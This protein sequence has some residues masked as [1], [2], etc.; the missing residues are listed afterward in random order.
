VEF[1]TSITSG[2]ALGIIASFPLA[3]RQIV[4]VPLDE[5]P[6]RVLA[7][8]ITAAEEIP[9]FS[10][11]L[12]DGYA[13]KVKDTYGARESM[14][15]Q[16]V[17]TGEVRVGESTEKM[18]GDGEAVYV[19][20]GAML[21]EGADGVVMQEH[22][23]RAANDLEVTRSLR[24]GENICFAGEDV[25]KGQV[26]LGPGKVLTPFDLGVLAALG[27]TQVPVYRRPEIGLI[28]SGDEVVPVEEVPPPGKIRDINSHTVSNLLEGKGCKIRFAGIA[29]DT[30]QDVQ[31]KLSAVREC[32]M[33]LLSGGSS[34]GQMD[35][36]TSAI[37]ALGGTVLF[38]GLN[39]KPGKP[40]IFGSLWGKPVFGLPG[41][42]VSCGMVVLRFV[43]PL[44]RRLKGET[45]E[46]GLGGVRGRLATN[47][48]SSYGIEEYV[49]VA[50]L[51]E[52]DGLV[53]TP[54]F[55]KSSVISMLSKADG[56]FIVPEGKEG[57]EAGEEVEVFPFA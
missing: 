3:E 47:V 19:A 30:L 55:A 41:H 38:H 35:F 43:L 37:E 23:R 57:L 20:T 27:V 46:A 40:T 17:Q 11:S 15:A 2:V 7:A 48:P 34:K 22:V 31:D 39:I 12:V 9:P 13:V 32:D 52:S 29:R 18:V 50:I 14:P 4:E 36:V 28:S 51:R 10:R 21:P 56:Y 5:A 6:S 8:G 53:V 42:P 24:R 33:I 1:L 45:G 25:R 26:V 44:V 49:R 16:L 54:I